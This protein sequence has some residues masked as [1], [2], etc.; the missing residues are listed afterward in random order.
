[1]KPL[2]IKVGLNLSRGVYI[3]GYLL[4]A[5]YSQISAEEKQKIKDEYSQLLKGD[6]KTTCYKVL[7]Y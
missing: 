2:Q 5:W 1:M 3:T 7:K 4:F 6:L